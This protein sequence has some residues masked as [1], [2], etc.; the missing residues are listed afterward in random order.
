VMIAPPMM[1]PT[2]APGPQRRHCALASVAV[3]ASVPVTMAAAVSAVSVFF[4][5]I[6]LRKVG[7]RRPGIQLPRRQHCPKGN[8]AQ[9]PISLTLRAQVFC[10]NLGDSQEEP[11]PQ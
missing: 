6:S 11:D 3:A 8:L 9:S 4:M 5:H 1:P 10:R 7:Q 2:T